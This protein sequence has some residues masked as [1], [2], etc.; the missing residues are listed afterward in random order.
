MS[1]CCV[2]THSELYGN[3][4]SREDIIKVIQSLNQKKALFNTSKLSSLLYAVLQGAPNA[5]S[6][7]YRSMKIAYG[8]KVVKNGGNIGLYCENTYIFSIQTLFTLNMWLLAYGVEESCNETLPEIEELFRVIDIA[9]MINDYLPIDIDTK[10]HEVEYM[11]LTAYHGSLKNIMNQI[12]RS[13]Y[14][15]V[16]LLNK[17]N[18][19]KDYSKKFSDINHF[20]ITEYLAECFNLLQYFIIDWSI[21]SFSTMQCGCGIINFDAKLLNIVHEKIINTMAEPIKKL[22][23]N[24]I[25]SINRKWD[26]ELFY[27][28]PM[29]EIDNVA[30]NISPITTL[31]QSFDGLYWKLFYLENNVEHKKAFSRSF[32]KIFENYI[33]DILKDAEGNGFAF[34]NEFNYKYEGNP[35]K[36]SDAYIKQGEKLIIIEAKAKSPL[37]ETFLDYNKK[38]IDNEVL[39]LLVDP[40]HQVDMRLCEIVSQ[41]SNFEDLKDKEFFKNITE[42]SVISVTMEKV[43]PVNSL[44]NDADTYLRTDANAPLVKFKNG[45][46]IIKLTKCKIRSDLICNYFNFNLDDFEALCL[47][48]EQGEDVFTLLERLFTSR[49]NKFNVSLFRNIVIDSGFDYGSP[50][51]VKSIFNHTIEELNKL[52]FG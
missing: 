35:K 38:V 22:I 51:A 20:T 11:Y 46:K 52:V 42:V 34:L 43:Q 28:T 6:T 33:Q 37:G 18:E 10:D 30:M 45:K 9:I 1:Y 26:F 16:T 50:K 49:S 24:A 47:L 36:S 4:E 23:N 39:D 31:Y 32:G 29:I 48:I 19:T 7:V 25:N 12:A 17:E 3:K 41:F 14:I 5:E 2:I 40:V 13:Y 15:F 44:L 27:R 8:S 21:E